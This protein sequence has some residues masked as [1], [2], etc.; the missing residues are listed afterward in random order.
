MST[1]KIGRNDMCPCG[2][3]LKYKKC[4]LGKSKDQLA[5]EAY[6]DAQKKAD[7]AG[8]VKE[9]LHPNHEECSGKIVK[10]HAIQNNRVLTALAENGEVILT[11]FMTSFGFQHEQIKGRKIATTFSGFCSYHDK[12]LFQDIEDREF[13][14]T[15]KQVFLYTY[16]TLAWHCHKKR[17][18]VGRRTYIKDAMAAKGH[19]VQNPEEDMLSSIGLELGLQDNVKMKQ[20]FDTSLLAESYS[21]VESTVWRIP[22]V[23]DFAVS[24]MHELEHDIKGQSLIDMEGDEYVPSIFLNIFPCKTESYCIWSWHRSNADVYAP[25]ARQFMDLE[26]VDRINY[27][28]NKLPRWTD[29]LVISPR[30]WKRWGEGIQQ[31]FVTHANFDMLFRN[32]EEEEN[33]FAYQYMDTPWDLFEER[34]LQPE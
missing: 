4:C 1:T 28:N 10:S 19:T 32:M 25:F 26:E 16:R 20:A 27:L 12:V 22:Y 18:Q 21:D 15:E 17:E 23:I 7:R 14:C 8:R 34:E 9:C 13:C 29:S 5:F 30:M 2:S 33:M 24:M 11:N 3:G 31:A 6:V